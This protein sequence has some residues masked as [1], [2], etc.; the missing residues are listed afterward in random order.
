M[1]YY[2]TCLK[3]RYAARTVCRSVICPMRS[4]GYLPVF[5]SSLLGC[6]PGAVTDVWCTDIFTNDLFTFQAVTLS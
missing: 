1:L 5:S 3:D 2:V 4:P 6:D